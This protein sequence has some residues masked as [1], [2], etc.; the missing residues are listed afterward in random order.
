M[1]TEAEARALLARNVA[2]DA[3]WGAHSV[4]VARSAELI[5][6]ALH[7]TGAEVVPTTARVAAVLHD[8]G[9]SE[10]HDS[11]GHLTAGH[12]ILTVLGEPTLA[13]VCLCHG[14]S[15]LTPDEAN[16]VGWPRA[17][18]RPRTWAEQAVTIADA[19]THGARTVFLTERLVSV[20]ER[21]R[22]LFAPT[23]YNLLTGIEPESRGLTAE[24]EARIGRPIEELCGAEHL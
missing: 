17:D 5:A 6:E 16:L 24:M 3:G 19:L 20:L 1:L 9:R 18:Y 12:R 15:G 21:Y 7:A 13:R 10:T 14:F 2:L 8:I 11:L 22:G 23:H 4:A